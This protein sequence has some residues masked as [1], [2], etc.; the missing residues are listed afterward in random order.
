MRDITEKLT[1]DTCRK[2][3]T[4][5]YVHIGADRKI[6]AAGLRPENSPPLPI[7]D[8]NFYEVGPTQHICGKCL[9][10]VYTASSAA[11]SRISP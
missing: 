5:S 11:F 6:T 3:Q 8:E 1:C 9:K 10:L 7:M 4:T 2:V